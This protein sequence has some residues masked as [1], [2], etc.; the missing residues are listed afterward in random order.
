VDQLSPGR[1]EHFE[2]ALSPE[3]ALDHCRVPGDAGDGL[4]VDLDRR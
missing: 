4:A 3:P 1:N 2:V